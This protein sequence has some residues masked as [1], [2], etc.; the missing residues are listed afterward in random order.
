MYVYIVFQQDPCGEDMIIGVYDNRDSAYAC[1][2]AGAA[3][4][5]LRRVEQ[6]GVESKYKFDEDFSV[7]NEEEYK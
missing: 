1:M 3:V 4:G 6:G 7:L 5:L 2:A